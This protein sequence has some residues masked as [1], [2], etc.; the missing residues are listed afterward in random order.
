M[1]IINKKTKQKKQAIP[2]FI[3]GDLMVE[4]QGLFITRVSRTLTDSFQIRFDED[5]ELWS[6]E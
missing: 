2:Y 5:T 6:P 1:V 4:E 3:C